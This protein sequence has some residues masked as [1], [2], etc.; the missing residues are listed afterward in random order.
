MTVNLSGGRGSEANGFGTYFLLGSRAKV[1][2]LLVVFYAS[3][4]GDTKAR[5]PAGWDFKYTRDAGGR[6]G[7]IAVK[8]CVQED[9]DKNIKFN[10]DSP[11]EARE[12]FYSLLYRRRV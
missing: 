10:S 3:Q 7:Y 5:P 2:D 1:G 12:N 9:L 6:S 4:Y 8:R 11:T